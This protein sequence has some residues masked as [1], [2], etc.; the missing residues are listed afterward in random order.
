MCIRDRR[1]TMEVGYW[2]IRGLG[3]PL[4]ML[5]EYA[6]PESYSNKTF[7][8]CGEPGSWDLSSW[9]DTKP[10]LKE[11][12]AFMNLP[13]ILDGEVVV[14]HTLACMQYAGKK[15]GLYGSD[16]AQERQVHQV[17]CEVQDLRNAAVGV[18]YSGESKERLRAHLQGPCVNSYGKFEAWLQQHSTAHGGV[19]TVC[20]TPTAGAVSYT[21]LRAHETVLDLVCRLLLEKKKK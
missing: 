11:R 21:H 12:N 13:Y 18:F 17:L 16:A 6:G 20:P 4:R 15:F 14:A 10:A 5:C 3:A 8:V 19:Y 7:Q 1:Y 9:F 2:H